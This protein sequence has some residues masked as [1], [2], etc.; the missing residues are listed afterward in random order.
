MLEDLPI[1]QL[2]RHRERVLACP[3]LSQAI[4]NQLLNRLE[5]S[6]SPLDTL[7]NQ[8]V[9]LSDSQKNKRRDEK[10]A[11]LEKTLVAALTCVPGGAERATAYLAT[12]AP[13]EWEW[14][15]LFCICLVQAA[16]HRPALDA[17]IAHFR[18]VTDEDD[19]VHEA[20]QSAIPVVGGVDACEPLAAI[21]RECP[22]HIRLYAIT[23]L[24]RIK[25]PESLR[26][27]VDL[28]AIEQ[29]KFKAQEDDAR[30]AENPS[31]ANSDDG[32]ILS[33]ICQLCPT[34]AT[35]DMLLELA[36]S[37]K[38]DTSYFD[39]RED[40]C[41]LS[42]ITG[43]AFPEFPDWLR[44]LKRET[45]RRA[46]FLFERYTVGKEDV[47]R[48]ERR[49]EGLPPLPRKPALISRPSVPSELP[50]QPIVEPVRNHAPKVGRNEPCPCGS[51][52][53]YKKCCIDKEGSAKA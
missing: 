31:S 12:P 13:L 50:S 10:S 8:L 24:E 23:A 17:L 49:V 14:L 21:V 52:K 29:A 53:K 40:C 30:V 4:R 37:E 36:R 18:A 42:I 6:E 43:A 48:W 19:F 2:V 3:S 41:V 22:W 27:L 32:K 20:C 7:W 47:E 51:G 5:L 15:E 39:L 1:E 11:L 45:Q 26:L 9:E 46:P 25:S 28:L 33:A 38:Y 16:R 44:E 34:G 35:F